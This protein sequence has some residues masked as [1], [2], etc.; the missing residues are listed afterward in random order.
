MQSTV[1]AE[2]RTRLEADQRSQSW[3]A[4]RLGLSKSAL[5]RRMKGDSDFTFDEFLA[6]CRV[7]GADPADVIAAVEPTT[8]EDAA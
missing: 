5:A 8:T 3:F 4:G 1:A 7:L 6:G 2:F